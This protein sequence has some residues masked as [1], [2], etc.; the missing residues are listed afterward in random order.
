MR[1]TA[2]DGQNAGQSGCSAHSVLCVIETFQ[3]LESV[4][5][6]SDWGN[7]SNE[8]EACLRVTLHA[9]CPPGRARQSQRTRH[10]EEPECRTCA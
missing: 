10:K 2:M 3:R 4:S 1:Y 5:R 7:K 6:G 8:P 9:T